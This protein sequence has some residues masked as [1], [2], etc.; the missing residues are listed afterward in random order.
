MR[1]RKHRGAAGRRRALREPGDVVFLPSL[2]SGEIAETLVVTWEGT[3]RRL[4]LAAMGLRR[5]TRDP[6]SGF[7]AKLYAPSVNFRRLLRGARFGIHAVPLARV[8]LLARAALTGPGSGIRPPSRHAFERRG[9]TWYLRGLGGRAAGRVLERRRIVGTDSVGRF[10]M[11]RVRLGVVPA[12]RPPMAAVDPIRRG[13][14]PILEALV[15]ASRLRAAGPERR[16]ELLVRVESSAR[17]CGRDARPGVRRALG[18]L[19][20]FLEPLEREPVTDGRAG[21]RRR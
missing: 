3:G 9:G 8:D 6:R 7:R 17:R 2:R 14:E 4:N 13:S 12:P 19:L 18:I 5:G 11:A 21:K 20:R 16:R 10:Q 15:D 1:P